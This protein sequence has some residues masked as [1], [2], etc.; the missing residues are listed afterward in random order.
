MRSELVAQCVDQ[1]M[2]ATTAGA[3]MVETP[4]RVCAAIRPGVDT[5]AP[6][7]AAMGAGGHPGMEWRS[8]AVGIHL[9]PGLRGDLR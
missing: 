3:G 8:S 2:Q 1:R 4:A 9:K 5:A 7:G 6:A